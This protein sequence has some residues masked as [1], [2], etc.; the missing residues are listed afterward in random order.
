MYLLWHWWGELLKNQDIFSM[1]II[2]IIFLILI[3]S[4]EKD[5]GILFLACFLL[6][7]NLSDLLLNSALIRTKCFEELT[8]SPSSPSSCSP[9]VTSKQ[10]LLNMWLFHHSCRHLSV[11][12]F[13]NYSITGGIPTDPLQLVIK[14]VQNRH[15]KE[16]TKGSHHLKWLSPSTGMTTCTGLMLFCAGV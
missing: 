8:L 1:S 7:L 16:Q 3:C 4:Y 11:P 13:F 6:T 9:L 12:L 14:V 10:L 15:A 5:S 2:S